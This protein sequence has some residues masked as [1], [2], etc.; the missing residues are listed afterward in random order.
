[1]KKRRLVVTG[2]GILILTVIGLYLK[3]SG[4]YTKYRE[5][6]INDRGSNALY[7]FDNQEQRDRVINPFSGIKIADLKEKSEELSRQETFLQ[8]EPLAYF[9]NRQGTVEQTLSHSYD[10]GDGL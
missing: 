3:L 2:L 10:G 1:M 8:S 4:P 9:D 6:A 5:T 7:V